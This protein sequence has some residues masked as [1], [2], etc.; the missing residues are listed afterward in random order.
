MFDAVVV[1][2]SF[3]LD[4]VFSFVSIE[5]AAKDAAGL[6]VILR[7][8]RV[9][10]I[11]NGKYSTANLFFVCCHTPAISS[12]EKGMCCVMPSVTCYICTF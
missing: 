5:S 6:M 1:I 4:I 9:T 11:I 12:P 2:V 3:T 10:R 8:W 7:L